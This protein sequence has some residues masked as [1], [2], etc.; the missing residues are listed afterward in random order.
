M[1]S[2]IKDFKRGEMSEN[3]IG[4]SDKIFDRGND[5]QIFSVTQSLSPQ[6][7]IVLVIF[8]TCYEQKKRFL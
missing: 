7:K 8:F 4:W 5:S 2:R 1:F 3:K 6:G